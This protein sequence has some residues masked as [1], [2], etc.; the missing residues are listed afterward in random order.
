[1]MG[2]LWDNAG[3]GPEGEM[4]GRVRWEGQEGRIV[5]VQTGNARNGGQEERFDRRWEAW[6]RLADWAGKRARA[7][8]KR[9]DW[10]DWH[11]SHSTHTHTASTHSTTTQTST[12]NPA[13]AQCE[14]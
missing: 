5:L 4:T 10:H 12:P 8:G 14:K 1:M 3:R 7:L 9:H 2:V 11:D 6:G 13:G